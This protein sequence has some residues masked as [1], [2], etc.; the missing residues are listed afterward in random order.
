MLFWIRYILV[1]PIL[2]LLLAGGVVATAQRAWQ[3]DPLRP[4]G[5]L[6]VPDQVLPAGTTATVVATL[7]PVQEGLSAERWSGVYAATGGPVCI[8]RGS[9]AGPMSPNPSSQP[10]TDYVECRLSP[11]YGL[12]P[13]RSTT[14]VFRVPA[15]QPVALVDLD[16][17]LTGGLRLP[18]ESAGA[19]DRYEFSAFR[20]AWLTARLRGYQ[21]IYL[22]S[23][24]MA[25]Y[26]GLRA[27]LT[28]SQEAGWP[29][30][31]LVMWRQNVWG[32]PRR[33]ADVVSN[34]TRRFTVRLAVVAGI[35]DNL[36]AMR[37]AGADMPRIAW[38]PDQP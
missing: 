33:P 38:P 2:L 25:D 26:T 22:A 6:V 17:L 34:L 1:F 19:A 35:D 24:N 4:A 7:R 14:P 10:G 9:P 15:D 23:V 5:M 18:L 11:E 30:G 12:G 21:P 16:G 32:G 31:P 37:S 28:A 27:R 8:V 29:A 13:L 3:A 20:R 36:L